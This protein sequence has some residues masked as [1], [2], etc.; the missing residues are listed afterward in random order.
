[1][2]VLHSGLP[3][4]LGSLRRFLLYRLKPRPGGRAGKVPHRFVG[5]RLLPTSPLSERAWLSLNDALDLLQEGH[6]DGIGLALRPDAQLVAVDLDG[7][8]T[9]QGLTPAAV[10]LVNELQSFTEV[11]V[12]GRGLHVLVRGALPGCRRRT[13]ELELIDNGFLALTGQRWPDTPR[14]ISRRQAQLDWLYRSAFPAAAPIESAAPLR[15]LSDEA[16][17]QRL[18]QAR[19]GHRVQALLL[20][21]RIDRFPT[22]SEADFGL[23]RLIG[24]ATDDPEQIIRLMRASPLCRPGRWAQGDYLHRTVQRALALDYP[25]RCPSLNQ[26][27]L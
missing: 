6:G 10:A 18:L 25:S 17:V 20:E 16:L 5:G 15:T 14:G 26:G 19:N 3:E 21:G 22:P 23:A 4:E 2:Q 9:G 12:S 8:V 13:A 1:M 11:S 27:V 24:W 7:V